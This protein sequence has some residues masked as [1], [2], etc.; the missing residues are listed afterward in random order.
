[1]VLPKVH[2]DTSN[3]PPEVFK[4]VYEVY[5]KRDPLLMEAYIVEY[6]GEVQP[7]QESDP[8]ESLEHVLKTRDRTRALAGRLQRKVDRLKQDLT[9]QEKQDPGSVQENL[10]QQRQEILARIQSEAEQI[11]VWRDRIEGLVKIYL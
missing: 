1:M 2:P 7:E 6:R 8:L 11:L 9:S 10:Q 4:T 3:T 5:K